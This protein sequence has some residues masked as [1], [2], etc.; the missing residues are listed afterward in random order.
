MA[1]VLV[2]CEVGDGKLK[3]TS[4]EALSIGQKLAS[5]SGGEL[6]AAAFGSASAGAA[7]D[8]GKFGAKKLWSVADAAPIAKERPVVGKPGPIHDLDR[9][10]N[11]RERARQP[12]IPVAAGSNAAQQG[13]V[14]QLRRYVH[15]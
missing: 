12:H 4:R 9:A 15:R 7:A 6:H 8:A 10:I 11:P 3:K 2:F 5:T 14:G 13:Q 1:N